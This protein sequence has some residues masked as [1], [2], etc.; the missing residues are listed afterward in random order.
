MKTLKPKKMSSISPGNVGLGE[1]EDLNLI[2]SM[3]LQERIIELEN[4]L[5]K[6]KAVLERQARQNQESIQYDFN[7]EWMY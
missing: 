2:E 1:T 6:Q 5:K 4:E 3:K 7:S